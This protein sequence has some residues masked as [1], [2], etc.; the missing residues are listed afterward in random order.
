MGHLNDFPS[1]FTAD[2]IPIASEN[3][4]IAGLDG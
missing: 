2:V 3:C 1:N 4:S